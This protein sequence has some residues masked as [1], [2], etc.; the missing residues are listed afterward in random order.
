MGDSYCRMFDRNEI[1]T[2]EGRT[3]DVVELLETAIDRFGYPGVIVADRYRAGELLDAMDAIGL[4]VAFVPRGQG[5]KDGSED[6]RAFKTAVLSDRVKLSPTLLVRSALSGARVGFGP[7]GQRQ[8][9]Q[10]R[11][12]W[13]AEVPPP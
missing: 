1:V 11:R 9:S 6:A 8:T 12:W 5:F 13:G 10:V 2:I 3:V 4:D 7:S